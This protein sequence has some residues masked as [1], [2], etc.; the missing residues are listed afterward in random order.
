MLFSEIYDSLGNAINNQ[1]DHPKGS[2][3]FGPY[4]DMVRVRWA[5]IAAACCSYDFSVDKAGAGLRLY[6]D[7]DQNSGTGR[8][9]PS[10]PIASRDT[11]ITR[12]ADLNKSEDVVGSFPLEIAVS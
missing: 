9:R 8:A 3:T 6:P 4:R 11:I 10:E 7:C 12:A 5:F 2:P 1:N